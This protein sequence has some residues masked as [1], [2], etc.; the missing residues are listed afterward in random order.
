MLSKDPEV[1]RL[2]LCLTGLAN[3][4]TMRCASPDIFFPK[5]PPRNFGGLWKKYPFIIGFRALGQMLSKTMTFA[6]RMAWFL[7]AFGRLLKNSFACVA[8]ACASALGIFAL[9]EIHF[10]CR[11]S[12]ARYEA[13]DTRNPKLVPS[14]AKI[15]PAALAATPK[16]K[17]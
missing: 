13:T 3:M 16:K 5:P 17:I 12:V 1:L 4:P 15:S 2:R 11:V 7:K 6:K 8:Y 9:L 14:L 10:G